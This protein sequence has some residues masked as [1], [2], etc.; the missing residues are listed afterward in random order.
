MKIEEI[1][2]I[3]LHFDYPHR[4]GFR[5][6]GGLVTSRTTSLIRVIADNGMVGLGAAYSYPDIVRVIIGH[7]LR[8]LL[9]GDDPTQTEALWDKMYGLT[10]WYGRKGAAMSSIGGLDI[11]FWDLRGKAL[12]RPVYELLGGDR[13]V[14]SHFQ[15]VASHFQA[16]AP[17]YAS[18]LFWHDDV[19]ELEREAA[20]HRENG[21]RRVKMRLGR[22]PEYDVAALDAARRGVGPDGDVLVD[23]SHRYSLETAERM[24]RAL[25]ERRAFWF[26][27][28]FPPEDIDSYVALRPRL[29]MPLAAGENDFGVQGFREMLRAGALDI[30]QPDACRAGGLTECFRIGTMAAEAGVRVATHTWSDAVALVANA[31]LIAALP[32]GVTVEVDQTGNPF[33]D[34]LL[35]EPLRIEDG[36]LQLSGEPGL[37]IDLDQATVDRLALGPDELMPDGNYSD[38]I[39]GPEYLENA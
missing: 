36:S 15:A 32:N 38:L 26:E 24:G 25:A 2:V 18:G 39:F 9:I 30:A 22:D 28:P 33:I 17:A 20:R 13:G 6:A 14:A 21:F 35:T 12:G 8:R 34:E 1:E 37:G 11:A 31:H 10:R 23:G 29:E 7:H 27:E 16:S 5:Y 3:N 4:R 19:A